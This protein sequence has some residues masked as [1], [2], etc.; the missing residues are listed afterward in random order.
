MIN[1]MTLQGRLTKDP[2]LKQTQGG[3]PVATFTIAW[4]EKFGDTERKLFLPCVAWN[5][6]AGFVC[7]YFAKGSEIIVEG[8]LTARKWTNAEGVERET[9]EL[10]VEKIHFAGKKQN[11][12][13][14]PTTSKPASTPQGF[15]P[16]GVD[17][18]NLP[19]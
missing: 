5:N 12:S 16:I 1:R 10:T 6:S 11:E 13:T 8:G 19:F 9:I 3:T 18:D 17:D 4:S 14:V 2:E 7:N 15:A